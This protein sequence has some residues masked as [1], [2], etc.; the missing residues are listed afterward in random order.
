LFGL[1]VIVALF[2]VVHYKTAEFAVTDK[3][4]LMKTGVLRR[5]SL[6]I[7]LAK[8]ESVAVDQG[9]LGRILGYGTII[10]RGT[11]GT[12]EPF[13]RIADP[14]GFRRHVQEQGSSAQART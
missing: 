10:V 13:R 11:G 8:I 6:E 1:G 3:R 5:R 14:M 4:V 9:I 12:Q 7:N 2:Q